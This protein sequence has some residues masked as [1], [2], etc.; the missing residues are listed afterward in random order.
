[1]RR[2]RRRTLPGL[3]LDLGPLI[4]TEQRL[5]PFLL[6]RLLLRRQENDLDAAIR[7]PGRARAL[8]RITVYEVTAEGRV[9]TIE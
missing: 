2:I 4:D 3:E 7:V 1:M 6:R 8:L 9:L 5:E